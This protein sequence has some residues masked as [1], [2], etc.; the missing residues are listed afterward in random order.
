M[1]VSPPT[2]QG[3]LV[4]SLRAAA[5]S[6]EHRFTLSSGLTPGNLTILMYL[7][8]HQPVTIPDVASAAGHHYRWARSGLAD[9]RESGFVVRCSSTPARL[10]SLM[11]V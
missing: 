3:Y 2:A 5:D 8:V 7:A 4:E 10:P 1:V 11:L 9:L 6:L